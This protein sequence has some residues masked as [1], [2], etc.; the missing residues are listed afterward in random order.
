M[1]HSML[2]SQVFRQATDL[3]FQRHDGQAVTIEE[4][5]VTMEETSG[6]DLSQFRLWYKQS[7]TPRLDVTS[8]YS[9]ERRELT[10][11]FQQH[12]PDTPGQTDKAPFLIPVVLGL[13][14]ADGSDAPL[15]AA[16]DQQLV[17][18]VTEAEQQVVIENVAGEVVPSLL[19]LSLIHI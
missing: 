2:G 8:S 3:Y 10:L 16:G 6:R 12:C 5:V 1:L 7:G 18:D 19:R 17:I 11:K 9:E 14:S 15:N 13:L 4:F